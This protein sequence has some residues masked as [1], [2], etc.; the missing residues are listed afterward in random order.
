L[1]GSKIVSTIHMPTVPIHRSF[2]G[3]APEGKSGEKINNHE[4]EGAKMRSTA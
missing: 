2:H 4:E 3:A 1:I